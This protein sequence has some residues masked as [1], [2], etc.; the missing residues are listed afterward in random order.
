MLDHKIR[1]TEEKLKSVTGTSLN[2]IATRTNLEN[3]LLELKR[4]KGRR[5]VFMAIQGTDTNNMTLSPPQF[6]HRY[7]KRSLEQGPLLNSIMDTTIEKS[8]PAIAGLRTPE[9]RPLVLY[10]DVDPKDVYLAKAGTEEIVVYKSQ[11]LRGR[12][13]YKDLKGNVTNAIIQKSLFP[14]EEVIIMDEE[15]KLLKG[16]PKSIYADGTLEIRD[17]QGFTHRRPAGTYHL[18]DEIKSVTDGKITMHS[19]NSKE[20]LT[21]KEKKALSALKKMMCNL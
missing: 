21:E 9:G 18:T 17:A 19:G 14:K 16:I 7:K 8:N 6:S 4:E 5:L 11:D 20:T 3:D 2:E 13:V 10:R 1:A 15:G 12:N